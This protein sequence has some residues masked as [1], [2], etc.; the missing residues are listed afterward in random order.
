LGG[1]SY[2]ERE[3]GGL[4]QPYRAHGQG[5]RAGGTVPHAWDPSAERVEAGAPC[6]ELVLHPPR[7]ENDRTAPSRSRPFEHPESRAAARAREA[8][9]G[10]TTP[11]HARRRVGT[12]RRWL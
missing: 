7:S 5:K 11:A 3:G 10:K 4:V 6:A 9:A 12:T 2:G 1:E 8:V